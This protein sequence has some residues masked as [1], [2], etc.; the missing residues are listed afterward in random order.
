LTKAKQ[1]HN[2]EEKEVMPENNQ[3]FIKKT[4][5]KSSKAQV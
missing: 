2:W 1:K 4:K 3:D 5:Q